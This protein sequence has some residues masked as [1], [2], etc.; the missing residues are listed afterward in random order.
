MSGPELSKTPSRSV[1]QA[2]VSGAVPPPAAPSRFCVAP[3]AN[4]YGP[5]ESTTGRGSVANPSA[6]S[7][8]TLTV[9][10]SAAVA[11]FS[12]TAFQVPGSGL[13]TVASSS[14]F[15]I[16]RMNS[17]GKA[18]W[19][20]AG[21]KSFRS[22]SFAGTRYVSL[23]SI[24]AAPAGT[25]KGNSTLPSGPAADTPGTASICV[26]SSRVSVCVL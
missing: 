19:L 5:P 9:I 25:S 17:P 21:S 4:A 7:P 18:R 12:T 6:V 10:W 2:I 26:L 16:G 24:L 13:W 8:V 15:G 22:Q 3:V 1:S 11:N 20:P 14:V 23:A